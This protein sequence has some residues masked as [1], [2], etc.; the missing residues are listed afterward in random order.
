MLQI[1]ST[2]LSLDRR[3]TSKRCNRL[4]FINVVVLL[5]FV[6]LENFHTLEQ[7]TILPIKFVECSC[8]KTFYLAAKAIKNLDDSINQTTALTTLLTTPKGIEF[9]SPGISARH[10]F[11]LVP[12]TNSTGRT[13][14]YL[15]SSHNSTAN[16]ND[17]DADTKNHQSQVHCVY[18]FIAPIGEQIA[19]K[20][21]LFDLRAKDSHSCT[22]EYLEVYSELKSDFDFKEQ[23]INIDD[24]A[25]DGQ[26]ISKEL[27]SDTLSQLNND[28]ESQIQLSKPSARYC[29]SVSP[30]LIVSLHNV[31]AVNFNTILELPKRGT[32]FKG[33]ATKLDFYSTHNKK[34]N[35]EIGDSLDSG[36]CTHEIRAKLQG[37]NS[38]GSFTSPTYPGIYPKGLKCSYKFI[39]QV[40]QRI[41]LEFQDF[42]LYSGGSH[43]PVDYMKVFDG[44][45][46]KAPIINT[47]CGNHKGVVIYSST[48]N[49]L[50]KFVTS[51]QEANVDN[52]GFLIQYEMS[53]NYVNLKFTNVDPLIKHIKGSECDVRIMS[54]SKTNGTIVSPT[55][56]HRAHT[57]CRYI[58]EGLS[59]SSDHKKVML[60]FVE[61]DLK[62]QRQLTG[63]TINTNLSIELA[64]NQK[65]THPTASS[66]DN[67]GQDKQ[68]T[69]S[70]NSNGANSTN[71][72]ANS[73]SNA[74][75]QCSDNYLRLYTEIK[76]DQRV[77]PNDYDYMYC[78][79]EVPQIIE[80]DSSS[81]LMEYNSGSV[82]GYF[83]AEYSFIVDY[84]IPG[85]Q[86]GH[87]C[88]FT[89]KSE[90]Q[91]FGTFNSPWYPSWY[92]N[93][94]IC[95]YR[96]PVEEGEAVLIQFSFFKLFNET[97]DDTIG[98]YYD[99]C[100]LEDSLEIYEVNK[101]DSTSLYGQDQQ[102]IIGLYCTNASPGPILSYKPIKIIFKTNKQNVAYGFYAMFNYYS[103]S[104]LN[105]SDFI[106]N[107]GGNIVA[108]SRF[109]KGTISSPPS[110]RPE[111]YEKLNHICVWDIVARPSYKIMITF[112]KFKLEGTQK[113]RGC[114][115]AVVRLNLG[116][117]SSK[118]LEFCGSR[119]S[120]SM[121][122][123]SYT[124]EVDRLTLTF[125]ST[126]RASGSNGFKA[127]WFEVKK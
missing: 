61:F 12:N 18:K 101:S 8:D 123:N 85:N 6:L 90:S 120:D 98:G 28:L 15:V 52:R 125:I 47:F 62:T 5:C 32:L 1:K 76:L 88:D 54:R 59:R 20:F 89:Y 44:S 117:S 49:L 31:V 80:S 35:L 109:R 51:D 112:D 94:L 83:R 69:D 29:T 105:S 27:H 102:K 55:I 70:N 3:D 22:K 86:A 30:P 57:I 24:V 110:Y 113:L 16:S 100:K 66:I 99:V 37:K 38:N 96:F 95:V 127:T 33:L 64:T 60:R 10:K 106:S 82:G 36:L 14:A 79:D 67:T 17:S 81:L 56:P 119:N 41:R 71:D 45:D 103:A 7:S 34:R 58:F 46:E 9:S 77:D 40:G 121:I 116:N 43:C 124:S 108:N 91:K 104:I 75:E 126:Q 107:C 63:N 23:G 111:I 13:S 42:D 48:E 97:L 87:L 68:T 11:K 26:I 4:V 122:G 50:L 65:S 92:I 84:R 114:A 53:S 25:S 72:N 73:S 118:L 93:D 39:G 74:T 2:Y 19:I 115:K 21:S 78:N